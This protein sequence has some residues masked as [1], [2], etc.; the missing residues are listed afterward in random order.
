MKLIKVNVYCS[1]LG[2]TAVVDSIKNEGVI[3][4]LDY[5]LQCYPQRILV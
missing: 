2:E 4:S 3:I 1:F 5:D